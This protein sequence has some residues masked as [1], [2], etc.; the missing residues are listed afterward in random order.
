MWNEFKERFM[1]WFEKIKAL[2]SEEAQQMDPIRDQFE[3]F[4]KRVILGN[5]AQGK[6]RIGV[7]EDAARIFGVEKAAYDGESPWAKDVLEKDVAH[8]P[9]AIYI[10]LEAEDE[11]VGFIG[12]RT[13]EET[14]LH[15]TNVAVLHDYRF[16]NVATL[17]LKALEK[18][19]RALDKKEITLE[20]RV[21]NTKA[22]KLYRK[23]GYEVVG[24]KENYYT[25]E[26]EDA[27]EMLYALPPKTPSS[28]H[29]SEYSFTRLHPADL[30]MAE[31]LVALV[32]ENY[33]HPNNWSAESFLADL[34]NPTNTYY[35]V[36]MQ[37]Q[38]VG[39]LGVQSVL[40][41]ATITNIVIAKDY[42]G[43]G[44]AQR[45]WQ[46]A[47]YDL[48]QKEVKVVFL[49]VRESNKRAQYLYEILG[50]EAF[51]TRSDYYNDPVEDAIEYRLEIEQR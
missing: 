10:V 19:A 6:I 16:L 40:D 48:K 41:E 44:L 36:W 29:S 15:I 7:R 18:I 5:G 27:V 31:A 21:S 3:N 2:F 32:Q 22:I 24:T 9:A 49:E 17:L 39:F 51:H 33:E 11:I 12:A 34:E 50:F 35:G 23:N 20:A 13:T 37:R 25:P 42:Q 45:L 8:N 46:M 30:A 14:D 47:L 43:K 38:L 1:Q 28:F 26:N 4:E